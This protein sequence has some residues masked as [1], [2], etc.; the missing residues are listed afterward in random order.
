[1]APKQP[2]VLALARVLPREFRERVFEPACTDLMLEHH[3]AGYA[4]ASA[5][6]AQLVIALECLRIGL[7]QF[8]W[9]H[10][11]P[12]R[13]ARYGLVAAALL[14]VVVMRIMYARTHWPVGR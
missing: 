11:R 7:P 10:G 1:M 4:S 13:A 3:A 12:T 8:F 5:L 2:L 6:R 9:S 14:A